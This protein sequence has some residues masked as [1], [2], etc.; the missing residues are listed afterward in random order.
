[1]ETKEGRRQICFPR[2]TSVRFCSFDLF[3][4]N[5]NVDIKLEKNVFCLVGANGLGKSSFLT[6][7]IYAG[8]RCHTRSTTA[9]P[10]TRRI[11]QG[12]VAG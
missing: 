7:L 2:V 4:R 8:D 3:K 11:F 10:V 6:T 5:E 12:C 9:V 1:M